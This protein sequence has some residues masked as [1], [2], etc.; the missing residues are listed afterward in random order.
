M[1]P[2]KNVEITIVYNSKDTDVS[3]WHDITVTLSNVVCCSMLA[4]ACYLIVPLPFGGSFLCSDARHRGCCLQLSRLSCFSPPFSRFPPFSSSVLRHP[5]VCSFIPHSL[6]KCKARRVFLGAG[7]QYGC[8]YF[9]TR[10]VVCIIDI[11]DLDCAD[12]SPAAPTPVWQRSCAR[13]PCALAQACPR[14]RWHG[15]YR[16]YY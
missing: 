12:S 6:P 1:Y 5:P 9:L 2:S 14:Q 16:V 7:G 8:I 4:S 15:Q 10:F 13:S 3:S 11:S